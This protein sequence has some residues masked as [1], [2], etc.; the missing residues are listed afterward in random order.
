MSIDGIKI[1]FISGVNCG[2]DQFGEENGKPSPSQMKPARKPE[3]ALS[4]CANFSVV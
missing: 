1:F 4:F 2:V 3:A